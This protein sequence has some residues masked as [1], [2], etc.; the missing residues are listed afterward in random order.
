MTLTLFVKERS[1]V[2]GVIGLFFNEIKNQFSTSIR[3]LRTNIWEYVKNDVSFLSKNDVIHQ[4]TCSHTSQQNDIAEHKHRHS[5][6]VARTM[7]I[8]M[9]VPKYCGVCCVKCLPFV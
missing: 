4:T 8:H 9:H 1:E 5:L 6:D 3:V 2:P 7:M